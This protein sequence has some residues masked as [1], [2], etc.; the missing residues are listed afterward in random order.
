M[1]NQLEKCLGYYEQ[2]ISQFES[3]RLDQAEVSYLLAIQTFPR[4]GH[5]YQGLAGVYVKRHELERAD[6]ELTRAINV[7]PTDRRGYFEPDRKRVAD[8]YRKRA[9][10]RREL[11]QAELAEQDTNAASDIDPWLEIFEGLLRVW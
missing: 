10:V 4:C 6:R 3:N 11:G 1:L 9:S 8:A 5:A 2:G 7:Y